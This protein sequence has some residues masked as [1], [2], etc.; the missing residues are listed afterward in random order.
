MTTYEN[1]V[2][3]TDLTHEIPREVG[4]RVRAT[5]AEHGISQARGADALGASQSQVSRRLDGLIIFDIKE[6]AIIA[7]LCG[8]PVASFLPAPTGGAR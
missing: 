5:M 6:L 4:D 1:P 8:V 3:S 2:W 7:E